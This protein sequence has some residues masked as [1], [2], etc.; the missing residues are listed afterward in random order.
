VNRLFTI[1]LICLFYTPILALPT[2][3]CGLCISLLT[4]GPGE[5]LYSAFGHSAL[6]LIDSTQPIDIVFNYGTFDFD[7]PHFYAKFS[8][9][10][11]KYFVS[12]E[13]MADFFYQ[14][15][16]EQRSI[17]EQQLQ[18]SCTE[19]E[20]LK[21]YL[22]NNALPV[23]K[24]YNYNFLFDNCSS[25]LKNI[26]AKNTEDSL[27]FKNVFPQR[28]A[29][30]FR[31]L[32]HECLDT[33]RMPFTTVGL[34]ILLG[35]AVDAS[36][37]NEEALFLPNYLMKAFDSAAVH[38]QPLVAEK[39]IILSANRPANTSAWLHP[40][41]VFTLF[42]LV[43]IGMGFLTMKWSGRLLNAIDVI[44]FFAT[45]IIGVLLLA[46][47]LVRT[48]TVCKNNFNLV[49]AL[50]S[51]LIMAFFLFSKKKIIKYYWLITAILQVILLSTWFLLPQQLNV[52]LLPLVGVLLLR[53]FVLY[54][55]A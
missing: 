10:N 41:G 9:G 40:T 35:T 42:L 4:C 8:K 29:V 14:Y 1:L 20:S 37:Q 36:I 22:L 21:K 32:I 49:W 5:E 12:I 24:Y 11:L 30:S 26:T 45:G 52:A 3:S 25:R 31:Q 34:D 2:D 44:L 53:S 48:D 55:K 43:M 33:A 18:L 54:K 16:Y 7:D 23:N 15:Q 46:L 13:N 19:K 38:G 47:W 17:I 39:K 27:V 6:R 51:H 50:P 28:S